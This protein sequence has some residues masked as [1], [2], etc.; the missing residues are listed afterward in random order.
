MSQASAERSSE[1]RIGSQ[2]ARDERLRDS[3][4]R[5]ERLLGEVEAMCGP[6]TWAKIEELVRALLDLHRA[7]L[8]RLLELTSD[9]APKEAIDARVGADELV[10]SLLLLHGL[11]PLTAAERVRRALD[12]LRPRL[13]SFGASLHLEMIDE[14]D[15]GLARIQV[16]GTELGCA[17]PAVERSLRRAI[18]DAAPDVSRI[19]VEMPAAPRPEGRLVQIGLKRPDAE[20]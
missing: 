2:T 9:G 4:R 13:E 10:A 5:I 12:A 11:H 15:G 14:T 7:G 19:E 16:I 17:I 20:R 3:G 8:A 1:T 6:P 18:E